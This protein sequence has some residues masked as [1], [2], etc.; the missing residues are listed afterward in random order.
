M[1]Q[2]HARRKLAS[3]SL[4]SETPLSDTSMLHLLIIPSASIASHDAHQLFH[5]HHFPNPG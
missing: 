3:F 5:L 1:A 4:I 2:D